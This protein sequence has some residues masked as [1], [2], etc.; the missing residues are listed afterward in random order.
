VE[1]VNERIEDE[2]AARPGTRHLVL[3]LSAVNAIDTSALFALGELNAML[4]SA[5]DRPAPGRGEGAGDGPPEA[6][7]AARLAE[8]QVFLS[9]AM[10]WDA[11]AGS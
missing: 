10:A 3:V 7:R 4:R 6:Q 2:L 5:R 11:L 8:G 9:T 1:A